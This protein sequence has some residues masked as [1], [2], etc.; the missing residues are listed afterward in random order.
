[1][2]EKAKRRIGERIGK[3]KRRERERRMGREGDGKEKKDG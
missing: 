2:G 1:M 3:K